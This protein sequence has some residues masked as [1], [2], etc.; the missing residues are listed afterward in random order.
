MKPISNDLRRRI[1]DRIQ[2]NEESQPEIAE[3][4]RR[5][6][7]FSGKTLASLSRNRQL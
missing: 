1:I 5:L 3:Q 4:L 6:A 2:D 7:V